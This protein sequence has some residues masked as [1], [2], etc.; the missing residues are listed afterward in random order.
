[1]PT[2]DLPTYSEKLLRMKNN[3]FS[4]YHIHSI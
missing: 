2:I 4:K 3:D 1:M